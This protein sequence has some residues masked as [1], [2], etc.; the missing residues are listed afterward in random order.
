MLHFHHTE[1]QFF[2]YISKQVQLNVFNP[3]LE[4]KHQISNI[5]CKHSRQQRQ[6]SIHNQFKVI[7]HRCTRHITLIYI[8]TLNKPN[9]ET[10]KVFSSTTGSNKYYGLKNMTMKKYTETNL[11]EIVKVYLM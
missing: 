1:S 4:Q 3:I 10:L 7:Q 6:Y 2:L 8:V 9:P 11:Q 5:F